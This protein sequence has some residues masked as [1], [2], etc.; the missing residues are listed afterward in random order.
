MTQVLLDDHQIL[1]AG[2]VIDLD[3]GTVRPPVADDVFWCPARQ[4][5]SQSFPLMIRNETRY[6][7]SAGGEVYPCDTRANPTT[8]P[9]KSVPLAVSAASD[10]GLRFVSTPSGVEAYRVPQ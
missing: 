4:T 6:D 9:P 2:Q 5:F 8:A 7:R 3:T 1:I 10:D